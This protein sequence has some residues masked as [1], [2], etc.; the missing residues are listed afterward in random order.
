MSRVLDALE[1][2][3]KHHQNVTGQSHQHTRSNGPS[4]RRVS[5]WMLVAAVVLPPILAG[6]LGIYQTYGKQLSVWQQK[7]QALPEIQEVAFDYRVLPYPNVEP[8]RNTDELSQFKPVSEPVALNKEKVDLPQRHNP[9]KTE[10]LLDGLDLS[11]LSP[12]LALKV[13]SVLASDSSAVV[14]ESSGVELSDLAV[15]SRQ[16]QGIL[17]PLNFQ[18]HVYSSNSGKRWVKINGTE[19]SEGDSITKDIQLKSIEP[20]RS[21]IRYKGTV[22]A[23]PALYEWKG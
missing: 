9:S 5:T 7:K 21:T 12:E 2:S 3:E 22:I 1:R 23:I 4:P 14:D 8:L 20:Q 18:T 15:S 6:G 19:Y 10:N 16:W 13:E 11:D 17:P